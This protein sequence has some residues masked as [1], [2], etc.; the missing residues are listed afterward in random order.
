MGRQGGLALWIAVGTLGLGTVAVAAA[1][2]VEE[3]TPAVTF[4]RDF[5]P[6][7]PWVK[8]MERP[9]RIDLCLNG[10]WLFQPVA[11]PEGWREGGG[12]GPDLTPPVADRWEATPI[13]IPSPWNVNTWGAGRDVGPG[14]ARP[15][16][17]SSVYFPSYPR[18]WDAARM[19]WLRRSVRLPAEW[20]ARRT[21]LHFEALAG[22]AVVVVNGVAV[23]R[24]FD[25]HLPAEFDI[26]AALHAGE[27]E[28]LVG[29]RAAQLFNRQ[30]PHYPHMRF[31]APLGSTTDHLVGIW[32]DVWLVGV[33]A[34][35]VA[36]VF[37]K[38]F[39][40][41]DTLE[42]EVTVANDGDR[43]A[44]VQLAGSVAPWA[45]DAGA[46]A[47]DAPE[48]R[49]HLD[50]VALRLPGTTL[51][52]PAHGR[53]T[54]T[55]SAAVRGAL[56]TWSPTTPRLYGAVITL[57]GGRDAKYTRFG[58]RQFSFA[59][60]ELRLNGQKLQCFGDL[61][62]PFGPFATSRRFIWG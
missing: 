61:L 15:Y 37:M 12:T 46:G 38:P 39:V 16:E 32:Q 28:L 42:A 60:P 1:A 14:T 13:K 52:V 51:A 56:A 21:L 24:C 59:G 57:D 6:A 53:A 17:P 3:A 40:D 36:E 7:E 35:H 43:A 25:Q 8:P 27:N 26:T 4:P 2:A 48:P 62:H 10:R 33:P 23:G 45:N 41:R 18:T 19:G 49:W 31:I 54:A 47:L 55:L 58:W 44:T 22:E 9:A 50:A 11:V 5:A 29:V 20:G 34:V 30:D